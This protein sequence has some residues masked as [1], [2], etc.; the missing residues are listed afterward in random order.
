VAGA[1]LA[2][3][4]PRGDV[5][6]DDRLTI[7]GD[8]GGARLLS[9]PQSDLFGAGVTASLGLYRP[10]TPAK[11]SLLA[12]LRLR[13]GFFA[14]GPPPEDKRLQDP[15][16]ATSLAAL[17]ALRWRPSAP[18]A[19]GGPGPGAM[20]GLW[21]EAGAGGGLDGRNLR[22]MMELG[23]GWGLAFKSYVVSPVLRYHHVI[24]SGAGDEG[25]D[26][27]IL[28]FG[29]EVVWPTR[30]AAS[31]ALAVAGANGAG[32]PGAAAAALPPLATIV[33]PDIKRQPVGPRDTDDDGIMD[34]DDDCPGKSED[35]DGFEDEDGCPDDD[36]DGDGIL[37]LFD[38]CRDDPEVVNGVND[39]DGCPDKGLITLVGDRIVL[40]DGIMFETGSS[41]LT[42]TGRKLLDAV[43]KLCRQHLEWERLAVEG[44]TDARGS[45]EMN[46]RLSEDR[47]TGVRRGLL[48]LGF[49]ERKVSARG[50]GAT[51]PRV[52]GDD[53]DAHRRNRRVELVV[54]KKRVRPADDPTAPLQ[55]GAFRP[56]AGPP[57]AGATAA[58]P[59]AAAAGDFPPAAVAPAALAPAT[60][61][62][63]SMP[64][65]GGQ[66]G[67]RAAGSP[68]T[69][70]SAT[71][72]PTVPPGTAPAARAPGA[73]RPTGALPRPTAVPPP[74]RLGSGRSES[75][76][77][78][79]EQAK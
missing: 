66:P 39:E 38:K 5:R 65:A 60:A 8:V 54:V 43:A 23:V 16:A 33:V 7:T 58:G 52:R 50:F 22:P 25:N 28:V 36:N 47:A 30:D 44:H 73:A 13:L 69:P 29:L 21:A 74:P 46:Q 70:T 24:Q 62:A 57:R 48:D 9:Q 64:P 68:A 27:K 55:Q 59:S 42:P 11:P 15:G 10:I 20:L 71:R 34:A 40:E 37:D 26:A 19:G 75:L 63:G 45:E 51:R 3:L 79:D 41:T 14:D 1:L 49:D 53:A 35:I 32:K 2:L 61:T 12:G 17:L 6:S 76:D 78:L 67:S 72:P 56:V 4:V 31:E 18:A 77:T